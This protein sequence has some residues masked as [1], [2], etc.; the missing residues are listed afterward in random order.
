[1]RATCCFIQKLLFETIKVVFALVV[2]LKY[3]EQNR[4]GLFSEHRRPAVILITQSKRYRKITAVPRIFGKAFFGLMSGEGGGL[5]IEYN[6]KCG[7]WRF[8]PVQDARRIY[9][10]GTDNQGNIY[11]LQ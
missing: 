3:T 9:P 5:Q 8:T 6:L 1:M 11:F 4:R 7:G 2:R 10:D